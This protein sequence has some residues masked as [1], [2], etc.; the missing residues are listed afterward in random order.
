VS[1]SAR[2]LVEDLPR[3][4][5][6]PVGDPGPFGV[7]PLGGKNQSDPRKRGTPNEC[8]RNKASFQP[9]TGAGTKGRRRRRNRRWDRLYKQSQLAG[10][11]RDG[12]GPAKASTEPPLGPV[13][14]NEPNLPPIGRKRRCPARPGALPALGANVRNKPNLPRGPG[15]ARTGKVAQAGPAGAKTCETRRPRQKSIVTEKRVKSL[16]CIYLCV[17][18]SGQAVLGDY[19]VT[20]YHSRTWSPYATDGRSPTNPPV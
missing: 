17:F 5:R 16:F 18:F 13:A 6:D 2:I 11:D 14:P 20:R 15:W 1:G 9:A 12:H 3:R 10:T 4:R 19:T 8:V 7:P